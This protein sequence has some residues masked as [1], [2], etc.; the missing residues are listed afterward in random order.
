MPDKAVAE[1]DTPLAPNGHPA[2]GVWRAA[3]WKN[4]RWLI[5]RY[6]PAG[7]GSMME[8][9]LYSDSKFGST[10]L[11]YESEQ[12]A[13]AEADKL[14]SAIMEAIAASSQETKQ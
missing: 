1:P 7:T 11:I 12:S 6:L 5:E 4:G 9:Q 10:T 3:E 8:H 2:D 14:N 13:A